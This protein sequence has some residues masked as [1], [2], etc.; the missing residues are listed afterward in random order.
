MLNVGARMAVSKVQCAYSHV[1]ILPSSYLTYTAN[2][3]LPAAYTLT[4]T[5]LIRIFSPI[6]F[7]IL[8]FAA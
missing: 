2:L 4:H 1:C 5:N 8:H 6:D 3:T 7:D